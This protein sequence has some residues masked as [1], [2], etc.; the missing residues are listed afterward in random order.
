MTDS[1]SDGYVDE[2][3]S[4]MKDKIKPFDDRFVPLIESAMDELIKKRSEYG[5]SFKHFR[6]RSLIDQILI[7][8]ERIKTIED[9]EVARMIADDVETELRGIYNYCVI[10]IDRLRDRRFESEEFEAHKLEDC[11]INIVL[12]S[13]ALGKA[14]N[15]DYGSCWEQLRKQTC[16]DMIRVRIERMHNICKKSGKTEEQY[17][18]SVNKK[19]DVLVSLEECVMDCMNYVLFRYVKNEKPI[20]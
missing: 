13:Q 11:Y 8:V 15:E 7:K 17:Q 10:L 4:R 9:N 2:S 1:I 3:S 19:D 14:K 20:I 18:R 12:Q 16:V 5:P 6:I